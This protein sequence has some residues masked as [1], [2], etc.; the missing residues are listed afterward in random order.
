M[1]KFRGIL[2]KEKSH[3]KKNQIDKEK[4]WDWPAPN[5][6]AL[7]Q[8]SG[9][10]W[11]HPWLTLCLELPRTSSVQIQ[12]NVDNFILQEKFFSSRLQPLWIFNFWIYVDLAIKNWSSKRSKEM[13]ARY[14]KRR[15]FLLQKST[16]SML[17]E[18][19]DLTS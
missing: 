6:G 12:S 16:A 19:E 4:K 17:W 1:R 11:Q 14:T 18:R 8:E 9:C 15:Y 7:E 13:D 10:S 2:D 5:C 3:R